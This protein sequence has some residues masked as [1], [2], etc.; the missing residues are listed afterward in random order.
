VARLAEP[1]I[2][3]AADL[4]AELA[5]G[6][7]GAR[8]S[9]RTCLDGA[10]TGHVELG[11][12]IARGGTADL[13]P[14]TEGQIL[15]LY[16]RSFPRDVVEQEATLGR[17]VHGLGL[18]VPA[19]GEIVQIDGRWGLPF[20]RLD[21]RLLAEVAFAEPETAESA[22]ATLAELHLEMHSR[23]GPELPSARSRY[24]AVIEGN[25]LLS[26]EQRGRVLDRMDGLPD[27]D[28][29]CHG[30]FH[31]GNVVMT[32]P[33]PIVIDWVT[34]HRG[35]PFEDAAQTV[36]AMTEWSFLGFPETVTRAVGRFVDAYQD[37]Y[38]ARQP[39]ARD[40]FSAWQPVAAAVRLGYP[41]PPTSTTPLLAI[42]DNT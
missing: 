34:G 41:H 23:P 36:V 7:V 15:K 2:G 24:R 8:R 42:V 37:R 40:E 1:A 3:D 19:V 17:L 39:H 14:W 13:Y 31:A 35:N 26:R 27:G 11:E 21:G 33:G 30:D 12:P 22:G 16:R 4:G 28:R 9:A 6:R 29:V 25:A 5:I 20:E 10:V 18:R 38:F 32:K